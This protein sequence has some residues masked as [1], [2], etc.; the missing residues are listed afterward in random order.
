MKVFVIDIAKCNGCY[1]CQIACKDEHCG[2][3]WMPYARPQPDTGQF[4][5]KVTEYTRG[6]IPQ[7]RCSFVPELCMHCADAPCIKVCPTHAIHQRD[8]GLV[9]ID[10]A[11][12]GGHRLCIDACPYGAI[13]FNETLNTAQ[14]CTGCAH[15]LDRGWPI[16]EPRCVDA[17]ILGAMMFGEEDDFRDLIA[18]AEVLHPEYG[19][20]PRVYYLNLPKRFIAGTVYDPVTKEVVIGANCTLS[21]D[22]I[23]TAITNDWGDF[24]FDGLKVGTFSLKIEAAER[25]KIITDINTAK[26]VSLGDIPL[27]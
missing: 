12:C 11:K 20:K 3:D 5:S 7:V 9:L 10:P 24:W 13:Y 22:G 18:K 21:G 14:K 25:T 16:K 27:A 15:L 19:L 17:C 8:D 26:D 4:W 6:T 23:A 1:A 2:N